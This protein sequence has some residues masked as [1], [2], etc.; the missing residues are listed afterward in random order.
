SSGESERETLIRLTCGRALSL[1]PLAVEVDLVDE[2]TESDRVVAAFAEQFATDVSGIGDN[3]RKRLMETLGD[4]A[5]RSVVAMFIADFVP[6][7][8]AGCEV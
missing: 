6:R 2:T 3:Q 5:F 1:P 8:W 7:M 4:N